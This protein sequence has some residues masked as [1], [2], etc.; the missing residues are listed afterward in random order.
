M[1]QLKL[2]LTIFVSLLLTACG[3]GGGGG[4]GGTPTPPPPT[5]ADLKFSTQGHFFGV[6]DLA[7]TKSVTIT[8]TNK[9]NGASK[10][11]NLSGLPGSFTLSNNNCTGQILAVNDSCTFMVSTTLNTYTSVTG[12]LNISQVGLSGSNKTLN[13]A[14]KSF[15]YM[16]TLEN[17][18]ILSSLVLFQDNIGAYN[19]GTGFDMGMTMSAMKA[20]VEADIKFPITTN[21]YSGSN[22]VDLSLDYLLTYDNGVD[23]VRDIDLV[24]DRDLVMPQWTRTTPMKVKE[25]QPSV[26]LYADKAIFT[27][28][29]S[30]PAWVSQVDSYLDSR[31]LASGSSSLMA[32]YAYIMDKN[33]WVAEYGAPYVANGGNYNM[34]MEMALRDVY[35]LL[36]GLQKAGKN[37]EATQLSNAIVL[38]FLSTSEEIFQETGVR[39]RYSSNEFDHSSFTDAVIENPLFVLTSTCR[40]NA[41]VLLLMS[42][43]LKSADFALLNVLFD[44]QNLKTDLESNLGGFIWSSLKQTLD[45]PLS[46]GRD[47]CVPLA[48]LAATQAPRSAVPA[49]AYLLSLYNEVFNKLDTNGG[50]AYDP[51]GAGSMNT[52]IEAVWLIN[53]GVNK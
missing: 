9:G 23:P 27:K 51:F 33:R 15:D 39:L 3:G 50:A 7:T 38:N 5:A 48:A 25:L 4:G 11:L 43:A 34:L 40:Q 13:F 53:D 28:T 2:V 42:Q 29:S 24:A 52:W 1:M 17:N 46:D 37:T 22:G 45:D 31:R 49:N 26:L 36:D 14:A 30:H 32:Q 41:F 20:L 19:E 16:N 35:I 21:I 18:A 10:A 8:V 12:V 47:L 6:L 44:N